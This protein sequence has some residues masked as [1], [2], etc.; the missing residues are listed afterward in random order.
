MLR[1]L[2]IFLALLPGACSTLD[3]SGDAD[4]APQSSIDNPRDLERELAARRS[5][6]GRIR[7]A[8]VRTIQPSALIGARVGQI[9]AWMGRPDGVWQEGENAMWRYAGGDCVVLLFLDRS[10]SVRQVRIVRADG[11]G[12]N[13]CENAIGQRVDGTPIS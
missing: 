6:A 2:P 8:A 12:A 4:S 5:D 10:D 11:S 9:Q 1:A 3:F 7:Q 13:G